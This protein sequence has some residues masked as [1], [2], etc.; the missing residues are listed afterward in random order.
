MTDINTLLFQFNAL[1]E[2]L[3]NLNNQTC[4]CMSR[5]CSSLFQLDRPLT[6]DMIN[7]FVSCSPNE[8]QRCLDI[9]SHLATYNDVQIQ[10]ANFVAN[11]LT[12]P[13]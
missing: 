11:L 4:S 10:I 7:S 9:K 2:T 12:Q 3:T 13:I 5:C 6:I 1:K 8:C